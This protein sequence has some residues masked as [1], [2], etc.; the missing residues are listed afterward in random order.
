[1]VASSS[2]KD[3]FKNKKNIK[4]INNINHIN[5]INNINN[6]NK[7]IKCSKQFCEGY[8]DE[9]F[10]LQKDYLNIDNKYNKYY[11]KSGKLIAIK[12]RRIDYSKKILIIG[13]GN[14]PTSKIYK[15][16]KETYD[17][18]FKKFKNLNQYNSIIS[19]IEHEDHCHNDAI[20]I[21]IDL[22]MNP[23]I[24]ADFGK[25]ELSF[26]PNNQYDKIIF[27]GLDLNYLRQTNLIIDKEINRLLSPTGKVEVI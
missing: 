18:V 25:Y 12:L 8:T 17:L 11:Y 1:M 3:N 21:D 22:T 6:I 14:N 4:N 10:K 16:S 2:K 15:K 20:T 5:N 26:L 23:T 13:C 7:I 9:L 19:R 24:V 27:E